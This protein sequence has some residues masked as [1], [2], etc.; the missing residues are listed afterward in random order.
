MLRRKV[1]PQADKTIAEDQVRAIF[2]MKD[3]QRLEKYIEHAI[4]S[5]RNPMSDAQLEAKFTGLA[6]GIL[7]APRIRQLMDLCWNAA[8]LPDASAIA[9][10]SVPG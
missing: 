1:S 7:P 10:A 8:K 9:R 3:G 2:F 4:G 6:A 5:T